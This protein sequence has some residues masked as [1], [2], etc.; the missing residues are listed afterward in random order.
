METQYQQIE[1]EMPSLDE[2]IK[3][4]SCNLPNSKLDSKDYSNNHKYDVLLLSTIIYFY[5][6][7][8]YIVNYWINMLE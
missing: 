8:K 6:V 5:H 1:G 4:I 2:N 7:I 3:Q